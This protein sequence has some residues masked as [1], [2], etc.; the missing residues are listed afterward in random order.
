MVFWRPKIRDFFYPL[1]TPFAR[2]L[3]K[4]HPNTISVFAL[5]IGIL[6][7]VAYWAAK[8]SPYYY[9]AAAG[10]IS[11]SGLG[12]CFDGI[13]AREYGKESVF[14]DFL[15]HFF[16][17]LVNMAIFI[18]LAFSPGASSAFALLVAIV[19]LLNSYLGTQIQ[20]SF[21]K[22]DYSGLGKA[23]LFIFLVLGSCALGFFPTASVVVRG[24]DISMINIFLV[25]IAVSSLHAMAHRVRLAF[26][27]SASHSSGKLPEK[28]GR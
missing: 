7:G 5:V 23:Q 27:L 14:G 2:P 24:F 3:R 18:G 9:F 22:R 16:D 10:L 13:V 20:A 4:L 12:D 6:A 21:G 19:T 15:D 8:F 17:R 1:L 25:V 28:S 26:Q 11:I